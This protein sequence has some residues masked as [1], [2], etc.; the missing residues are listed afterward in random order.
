[1]SSWLIGLWENRLK[2]KT[3][4]LQDPL[5]VR[6]P[7]RAIGRCL[8][9]R[10]HIV[11]A[12]ILTAL[13]VF[14]M[15]TSWFQSRV[16]TLVAQKLTFSVLPGPSASIR[17]PTS[18]PYNN[19][20]GYTELPSFLTR[21]DGSPYRIT[22]Q[23]RTSFLSRFLTGL[24]VFPIYREKTQA[25]LQILDREGRALFS[26]RFPRRAYPSFDAIPPLVVRSLLFIENREALDRI[27]PYR[28]PSVEWDRL[29]GAVLDLGINAIDSGHRISGGSTLAT[30]IEKI[31]HSP[32]GRTSSVAEKFRQMAAASL[33]AYQ[34]GE[35]TL[36]A[37]QRI[38]RD[39][40]DS[41]PLAAQSR[42]GEVHGLGDGLWAW[43][44]S[45][46]ATVNALLAGKKE[47][48]NDPDAAARAY[49]QVLSLLLAINSPSKYLLQDHNALD[50]RTDSYL[51][52]LWRAG[53]ISTDLRDRA[54]GA[55]SELLRRAPP[56]P[57]VSFVERKGADPIRVRLLSLLGMSSTYD[58][59][60][61]DL[62]VTTALDK[63]AQEAVTETLQKFGDPGYASKAGLVGYR[64]LQ[65]GDPSS[66]IYSFTLYERGPA[67]NFLRVQAD[68]YDQPLNINEGTRLELG[69]TA[70][71]RT[72]V[73]Y[74]QIVAELHRR[75]A[76]MSPEELQAVQVVP[77]DHLSR[78]AIGHLLTAPDKSL[79]AMLE[80]AMNRKYSAN[81]GERFFTGGGLH[82]FVNFEPD[83]NGRVLT[84]NEAFERSVNLVF[85]RLMR[86]IVNY[87]MFQ[88]PGV[89]PE[90]LKD[91]H[92]PRR[93]QYLARF[94]DME[95]RQFL[96]QFYMKYRGLNTAEALEKLV[97]GIRPTP[98]RLAV[99][100]R[101][102]QP[103]A[104]PEQ[105]AA[106]LRSHFDNHSLRKK[107]IED[108][109]KAYSPEQFNLS[110]RGY[111]ARIH[112]LELWLLTYLHQHP[113]AGLKEICAASAQERQEVYKWLLESRHK[114][115]QD[116]RIRT[117]LEMDAFKKIHEAWKQQGYPFNSL[118]PSYATAIGSS[119]DNPAALAELVGI[120]LND[121][122]RYPSMRVT[123]LH[124]AA[125]TPVETILTRQPASGQR[126]YPAAL[127]AVVKQQL[128][129]VVESGTGRRAYKSVVLGNGKIIDVG[130][131]TGTGDNR[132]EVTG[133]KGRVVG[134]RVLNRTATFV[135][136]IG[137]RFFGTITAF[138]PGKEAAGYKFT[139]SLPVQA[140][141]D[142]VP[143]ILPLIER[144]KPE[145][146]SGTLTVDNVH[147]KPPKAKPKAAA[148][149]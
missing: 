115:A 2:C 51:H 107:I 24:G 34:D 17:Y 45:D 13:I 8:L 35:V 89:S 3:L 118:V 14:E 73:N 116:S 23:A 140:F 70:K 15:R 57:P 141:K 109:Y 139:S 26:S 61:L 121:G 64:L 5:T 149:G 85:I 48:V 113:K 137:D 25:G 9:R 143:S 37:R 95:G 97:A 142:L 123:Q 111:L 68:N 133:S 96:G 146:A 83:D 46:F 67:A 147:P 102:A 98:K 18:G 106:F 41:I 132:F 62:S 69:S 92:D 31:R 22:A 124:F 120:I 130:G 54:L 53:I 86:D 19:R 50:A 77:E 20:L 55:H 114:R 7:A 99:I 131:K 104:G 134:E 129:K 56:K 21:L 127:A 87:Y 117:I 47:A 126:V 52:L 33:R 88:M 76:R 42:Y 36:E 79:P 59:D 32:S 82:Q 63:S 122:L 103:E 39:Y 4:E 29:A 43:Y 135:F 94:A 28:N 110:D 78:W 12:I 65:G 125:G 105:F 58:L 6:E 66:V 75:Y 10:R 1:V 148:A 128:F 108:L 40:I 84:V 38:V 91:P 138:V 72:L 71:L 145:A 49:R 27:H 16:L 100:Y 44:G 119:G 74:L 93:R 11:A 136:V 30:Q 81:P 60:R 144:P 80:A 90:I 112:P 101:S